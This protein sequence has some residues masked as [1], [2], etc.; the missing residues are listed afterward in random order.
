MSVVQT[1]RLSD[2]LKEISSK[3]PEAKVLERK[4]EKM[5]ILEPEMERTLAKVKKATTLPS[6][7]ELQA[8]TDAIKIASAGIEK[9][10]DGAKEAA[11]EQKAIAETEVEE[12]AP[13]AKAPETKTA[14][15]KSSKKTKKAKASTL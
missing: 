7:A 2:K 15:K 8:K 6:I 14:A 12:A 10:T 5:A 13:E 1:E 4:F 9:A 3:I 11:E